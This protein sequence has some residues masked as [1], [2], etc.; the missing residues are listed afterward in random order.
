MSGESAKR[1]PGS[2]SSAEGSPVSRTAS[3]AND[4][5]PPTA[6]GSGRRFGTSSEDYVPLGSSSRTFQLSAPADSVTFCATLPTSGSMRNGLVSEHPTSGPRTAASGSSSLLPTPTAQ[7]YGSN[8]GGSAGRVGKERL[9][10]SALAR[11]GLLP[12]P[13]VKGNHNK[14]GL[15]QRSGNGLATEVGGPL[16]ARFVEWM[17]GFPPDFTDV[18]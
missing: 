17:M 1:P 2:T 5:A 15:S 10:L 13:T 16:S 7:S 4:V 3:P 18:G 14:A 6:A 11:R 12:T 8:R 9:S